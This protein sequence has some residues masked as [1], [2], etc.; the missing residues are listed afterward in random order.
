MTTKKKRKKTI[1]IITN[2]LQQKIIR[3]FSLVHNIN[4]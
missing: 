2:H 4:N 1:V 3:Q